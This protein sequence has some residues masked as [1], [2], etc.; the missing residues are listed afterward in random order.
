MV[1]SYV[2]TYKNFPPSCA[3]GNA[4]KKTCNKEPLEIYAECPRRKGQNS[5]GS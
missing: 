5:G 1:L 4:D 2:G 3:D